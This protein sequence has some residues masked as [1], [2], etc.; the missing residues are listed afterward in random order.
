MVE[1]VKQGAFI[2]R[3]IHSTY[4]VSVLESV[5]F[6][7]PLHEANP[8]AASVI[9]AGTMQMLGNS[10]LMLYNPED[11]CQYLMEYYKDLGWSIEIA[12]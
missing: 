2:I 1:D 5:V 3:K 7:K 11:P 12:D 9:I 6:V 10:K 8:V 4:L